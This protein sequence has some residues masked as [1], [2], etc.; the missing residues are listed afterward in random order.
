MRHM[1]DRGKRIGGQKDVKALFAFKVIG[2]REVGLDERSQQSITVFY[3][4][5]NMGKIVDVDIKL[6]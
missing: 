2:L 5:E 4:N 3:K 1:Q 6:T